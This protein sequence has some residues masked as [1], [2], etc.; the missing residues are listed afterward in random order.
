VRTQRAPA[1]PRR[2]AALALALLLGALAIFAPLPAQG[3]RIQKGDLRVAIGGGVSPLVLPRGHAAP[4]TL[5]VG[6]R[7]ETADGSPLPR[8]KRIELTLAG[9]GVL[10]TRGLPRC[11]RA[12]LANAST[13]Q[14][15]ARCRGALV[16]RGSLGA[17]FFIPHQAPFPI[18]TTLL[19]FNGA[20]ADGA[21]AVW[22]H[23]YAG[24]PPVSIVFPFIIRR[25]GSSLRTT[26]L[27]TVPPALGDLPHL[28]SFQLEL[29]RRYRF[30]GRRRSYLSA[31]CP[32]PPGFTEGFLTIAQ[33][34]YDFADGRRLEIGAVRRCH[35]R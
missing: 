33:A 23:A 4:V 25:Q 7:I 35:T 15:L 22:V 12:R 30:A 28:A 8:L 9:Q 34:T 21:P 20:T 5:R 31:S 29:S 3:E 6:G 32:A 24:S 2:R 17:E 1:R 19:A 16:G 11:S 14:A 10:S 18:H 26:L 27:A 13:R